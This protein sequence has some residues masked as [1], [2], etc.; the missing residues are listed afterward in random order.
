MIEPGNFI[1]LTTQTKTKRAFYARCQVKSIS[2]KS[3]T[4]EYVAKVTQDKKTGKMVG[5]KISESIAMS[6]VVRMRQLL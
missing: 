3:L 2:T 5:E 4:I 1:Q 6:N